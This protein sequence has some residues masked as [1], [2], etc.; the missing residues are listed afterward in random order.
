VSLANSEVLVLASAATLIAAADAKR[1]SLVI[2]NMGPNQIVVGTSTV[3]LKTG[4]PLNGTGAPT[5]AAGGSI[6]IDTN[7]SS[8]SVKEAWYGL[9][10]TADQV[11]GAATQVTQGIG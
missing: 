3:T 4:T 2:T 1:T 10:R 5:T 11:T 9:A 6:Q 7:D 8:Q